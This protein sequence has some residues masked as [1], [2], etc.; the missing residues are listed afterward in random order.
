MTRR[1]NARGNAKRAAARKPKT[2]RTTVKRGAKTAARKRA[3]K[4]AVRK[5]AAKRSHL[6][7]LPRPTPPAF[8]QAQGGSNK[9]RVLFELVRARTQLMAALQGLSAG[10]GEQ[11]LGPGKWSVR[12]MVLH[13]VTRDRAR[14]REM[15]AALLGRR[16]S[17]IGQ[18]EAANAEMNERDLAPLRHHDWDQTLRLLQTT[19][20][21]LMEAIEAVSDEPAQ[22][23]E[24]SHPF[25][26]MLL[27]LPPHDRHHAEVLKRW[28]ST[29]GAEPR[30]ATARAPSRKEKP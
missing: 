15:E 22:V 13:L 18:G 4:R 29:N 24:T 17:W 16:G 12:E 5:P 3:A 1:A 19:R 8:P 9:Q 21:Q 28:R 14:L 23:W 11:P 27:K 20:Q 2:K 6:R 7:V 25:G 10:A 30:P 26:E